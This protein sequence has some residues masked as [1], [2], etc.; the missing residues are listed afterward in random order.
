M[1]QLSLFFNHPNP[2]SPHLSYRGGFLCWQ[3]CCFSHALNI[4]LIPPSPPPVTV[5]HA[6]ISWV[7]HGG[8]GGGGDQDN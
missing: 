6:G 3:R 8:G 2:H 4:L 7:L 5:Q 1:R